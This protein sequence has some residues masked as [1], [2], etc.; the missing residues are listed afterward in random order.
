MVVTTV[1]VKFTLGRTWDNV[2]VRCGLLLVKACMLLGGVCGTVVYFCFVLQIYNFALIVNKRRDNKPG[3]T[4]ALQVFFSF[5]TMHLYYLRTSH[6][7]RFSSLHV[8]RV[9]PG[10]TGCKQEIH[11]LLT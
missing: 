9:C 11:H 10:E 6:R 8:G 4:L 1:H 7:D 2:S 5:F 3:Q